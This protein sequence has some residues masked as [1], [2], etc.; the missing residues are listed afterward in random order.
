MRVVCFVFS[1]DKLKTCT[2]RGG[3]GMHAA[4]PYFYY[5]PHCFN[6]LILSKTSAYLQKECIKVAVKCIQINLHVG[7]S[8]LKTS[9]SNL[10]FLSHLYIDF[11]ARQ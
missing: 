4:F 3:G 8:E 10:R 11:Y 1:S 2:R 5:P 7:T 9:I 6:N